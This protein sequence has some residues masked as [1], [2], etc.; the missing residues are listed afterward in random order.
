MKKRLFGILLSFAMMLTMMPV[1]GQTAY[2][3][4]EYTALAVGDVL[5]VG[6]SIKS[7][8]EY[9]IN[10]YY[11]VP[12]HGPFTLVR[13]DIDVSSGPEA[14]VSESD[15][16]AYYLF[17]NKNGSYTINY[18]SV[19]H[20][21]S[22]AF[23]TATPNSDGI[24]VKAIGSGTYP[25]VTCE[26]HKPVTY[27]LWVG[28]TQVTSANMSGDGWSYTRAEGTT[29][30]TLTLNNYIYNSGAFQD[31]A[32]CANENLTIELVG[33]NNVDS[34]LVEANCYAIYVS[35][36][37]TIQGS[38][39]LDTE[40]KRYGIYADKGLT[41]EGCNVIARSTETTEGDYLYRG[42]SSANEGDITIKNAT[43]KVSAVVGNAIDSGGDVIIEDSTVEAHST[44]HIGVFSYEGNVEINAG[45]KVSASG[46]EQAISG[47]VK[48]S[49]A[50]TGWTDK[51]GSQ[52]EATIP[53]NADPGQKLPD[54]K[55]VQFPEKVDKVTVKF[56]SAGGSTVPSQTIAVNGKATKPADPTKDGYTFDGWYL[57]STAFDFS[58][59]VN[60]DITLVAHW[61]KNS[62][63]TGQ[64]TI[65][66]DLN[67]GTLN[68]ETGKVAVKVNNGTEITLPAP[69]RDGYTFDYW[70][71]SKYNAGDQYTVNGD[72]TFKAVWK[73]ADKGG[74]SDSDNKGGS[75]KKGVKTGDE[76]T[77]G[78]WIVLLVA[79]L[80]GTTGMVFARKRRND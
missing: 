21:L 10:D 75:S 38:G 48:N 42:I 43:V 14:I 18:D 69:T 46:N 26:V 13:A 1:L 8:T 63:P 80:T 62:T 2:A 56:D 23:Y 60:E 50:G 44:N 7:S 74:G 58:T 39:R 73:T 31:S 65:T 66:Y 59:A 67:G 30:A 49:I 78:A 61:K 22:G 20:S 16:G 51:A 6:D 32:I 79:A 70:Q 57:G 36:Q 71:G 45:S 33:N 27:P 72:H 40:G 53:I 54:Y 76:N 37:L 5:H 12:D 41:I 77:L 55:K 24:E 3:A 28:G 47:T 68:G 17:K 11:L 25:E 19:W 15:T 35:G 34:T 52:G 4:T 29:P 9:C 64:S